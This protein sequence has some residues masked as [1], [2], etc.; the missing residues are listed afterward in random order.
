M[1]AAIPPKTTPARA[2]A[3]LLSP[4]FENDMIAVCVN[5]KQLKVD[6]KPIALN[7][8]TFKAENHLQ[9]CAVKFSFFIFKHQFLYN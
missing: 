1:S 3:K 7:A 2:L 4:L 6:A 5:T 9:I 8:L